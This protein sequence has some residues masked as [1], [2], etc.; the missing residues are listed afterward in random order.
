MFSKKIFLICTYDTLAILLVAFLLSASSSQVA[1]AYVDP[2]VMTYA[3]QALAGVGV[4]LSTVLGVALRKTR[5]KLFKLLGIDEGFRKEVEPP[6]HRVIVFSNSAS[7]VGSELVGSSATRV[8]VSACAAPCPRGVSDDNPSWARRLIASLIVVGF[9]GFTLGVSAPLE[10]VAGSAGSLSFELEDVAPIVIAGA[11]VATVCLSLL[12]SFVPGKVF[13]HILVFL[14]CGGLC[15][16]IQSL[17]MNAGLPAAD[18]SSVDFFRDYRGMVIISTLV[19]AFLLVVPSIAACLNRARSRAIVA[20]LSVCL[21]A[22]QAV[23]L[24][25]V[26]L[27]NQESGDAVASVEITEDGLFEVSAEENVIVFVLDRYETAFMNQMLEEDSH[28]LDDFTGFTYYADHV[29]EMIPTLHAIPYLLTAQVPYEDEDIQD[30]YRGRYERSDFLDEINSAG[31]SVGIYSTVLGLE[32]LSDEAKHQDIADSTINLHEAG[33][34]VDAV[35]ALKAMAKCALYRDMPW[36]LKGPFWFYTD[37]VNHKVLGDADETDPENA[38]YQLDDPRFFEQLNK[39]GL[40]IEDGGYKGAFRFIHLLGSHSPYTMNEEAQYVGVDGTDRLGQT[41]GSLRIVETYLDYLR[42]MGLYENATIIVTSDH[43]DWESSMDAPTFA[44]SPILLVKPSGSSDG[45]VAVS[46]APVS[47]CDFHA[48]VLNAI[49]LDGSEYGFS[50]DS[51]SDNDRTRDTYMITSDG[52]YC[53]DL[54]K[55]QVDGYVLDFSNWEYTE[56]SWHINDI[57]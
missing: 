3:V 11:T 28:L 29:G 20:C 39:Y 51:V 50:Y 2:S 42:E 31:Y 1:Y 27:S 34:T 15:C 12:V 57:E 30:Y 55:Y 25:S 52:R 43:G 14:F 41:I 17:F 37:E 13:S 54:L 22:V 4:A 8:G 6:V 38:L 48:T 33:I 49:G 40:T 7:S 46:Y 5:K 53:I 56:S 26:F 21:I 44:I 32:Y 47:H 10:I 19:W 16:Y 24:I 18:G 36:A 9:C 35:G 45:A 23:G